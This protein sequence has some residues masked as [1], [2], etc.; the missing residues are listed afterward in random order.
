MRRFL[1][2]VGLAGVAVTAAMAQ[3]TMPTGEMGLHSPADIKWKDGPGSLPPGAK[4]AV[5][6]GDPGKDGPFVMRLW[7]PDNFRILPHWHPKTERITVISG[8]FNLGMGEKF[9]QSATRAMPAGT[10][11]F[12]GE[13]MRHFAW[14][15]GETVLQLHGI[16]PW[17]I[18]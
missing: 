2:A 8:T 1:A 10:Y 12:W 13:G 3:H 7:F 6:E 9:D 15:K 17:S 18:T 16:G 14:T 4:F 5:L 11:G